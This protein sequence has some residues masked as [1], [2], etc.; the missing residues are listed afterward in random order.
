MTDS[1]IAQLKANFKQVGAD[2]YELHFLMNNYYKNSSNSEDW[3]NHMASWLEG[4][5]KSIGEEI[6]QYRYN[7]A[8]GK[9]TEKSQRALEFAEKRLSSID[10]LVD[11]LKSGRKL[12]AAIL[13]SRVSRIRGNKIDS[14]S[15]KSVNNIPISTT[16]SRKVTGIKD[17]ILKAHIDN[18]IVDAE[19]NISIY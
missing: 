17:I 10:R 1:D 18:C 3:N 9:M 13:N 6:R 4:R 5:R 12:G 19:G 8:V 15:T 7:I 11:L 16:I 2:S 14:T